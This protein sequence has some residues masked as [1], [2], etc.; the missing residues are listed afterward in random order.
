VE[1]VPG[2]VTGEKTD[3][4]SITLN[5]GDFIPREVEHVAMASEGFTFDNSNLVVDEAKF[6]RPTKETPTTKFCNLTVLYSDLLKFIL[7]R[8]GI[9]LDGQ[10]LYSGQSDAGDG[11]GEGGGGQGQTLLPLSMT[12]H[13]TVLTLAEGQGAD[14]AEDSPGK[15]QQ[16]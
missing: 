15:E 1:G 5:L 11:G 10:T 16:Y 7:A 12:G 13:S 4:D 3:T 9:I 8:E 2:D 14:I 6:L